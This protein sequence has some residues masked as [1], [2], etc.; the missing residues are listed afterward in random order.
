MQR[1]KIAV[2]PLDAANLIKETAMRSKLTEPEIAALLWMSEK[3]SA[4]T[5]K[6]RDPDIKLIRALV[7]KRLVR[8]NT[9]IR[10][11]IFTHMYVTKFYITRKGKKYATRLS[12]LNRRN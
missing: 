6:R 8:A 7:K 4:Y 3:H 11:P 9:V 1:A 2:V 12:S 5:F 10:H